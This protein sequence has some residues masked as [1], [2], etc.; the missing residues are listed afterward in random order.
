M[1]QPISVIGHL[2]IPDKAVCAFI[3]YT[4]KRIFVYYSTNSFDA[5]VRHLKLLKDQKHPIKQ[6]NSDRLKLD[7]KVLEDCDKFIGNEA[8]RY[9][10]QNWEEAFSNKM[11]QVYKKTRKLVYAPKFEAVNIGTK[12]NEK[13]IVRLYIVSGRYKKLKVRDF[14]CLPEATEYLDSKTIEDLLREATKK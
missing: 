6:F 12:S 4:D 8:G 10:A 11:Y 3:N 2:N 14:Q 5:F 1:I 7:F 9:I 13:L